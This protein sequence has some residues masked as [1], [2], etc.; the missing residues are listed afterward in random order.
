M[1]PIPECDFSESCGRAYDYLKSHKGL[2]LSRGGLTKLDQRSLETGFYTLRRIGDYTFSD[3]KV[4]WKYISKEFVCAV[5]EPLALLGDT[6][7]PIVVQEKLVS[8]ACDTSQEAYYVCGYLSSDIVKRAI[9]SRMVSTQI[10]AGIIKDIYIPRLDETSDDHF[11]ISA[12]CKKGHER[13]AG[14]EGQI[15]DLQKEISLVVEK[16]LRSRNLS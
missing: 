13:L 6:K 4:C 11:K 16:L 1:L 8:I 2:L 14:Q 5:V 9:E 12:L 3:Y 7:K 15:N 10:S